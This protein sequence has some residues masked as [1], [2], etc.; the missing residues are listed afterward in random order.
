MSDDTAHAVPAQLPAEMDAIFAAAL[1]LA[2]EGWAMTA[3]ALPPENVLLDTIDI[4]GNTRALTRH[5]TSW[6][7]GEMCVV[8]RFV[9]QWWRV[10]S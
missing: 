1:H 9:P 8:E 3:A 10:C 5:S 6:V 4:D 7:M 2:S